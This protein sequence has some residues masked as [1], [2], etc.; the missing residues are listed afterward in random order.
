MTEE[1]RIERGADRLI[2]YWPLLFVAASAVIGY[3]QLKSDVAELKDRAK[4]F[5]Q[6]H[7]DAVADRARMENDISWIKSQLEWLKRGK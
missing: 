6:R 4:Q 5:E 3:V 2:K 1:R 7:S